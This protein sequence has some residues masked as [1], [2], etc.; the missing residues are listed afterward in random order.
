MEALTFNLLMESALEEAA[1]VTRGFFA[2]MIISSLRPVA[3]AA[4]GATTMLP[5]SGLAGMGVLA[6]VL[7]GWRA[8][9]DPRVS[10]EGLAAHWMMVVKGVREPARPRPAA[11]C[12][13]AREAIWCHPTARRED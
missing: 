7:P 12:S 4:G 6:E 10:W 8:R 5:R 11:T 9:A 2:A 13:G 3:A 1:E